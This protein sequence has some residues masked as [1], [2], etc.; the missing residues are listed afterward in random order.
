MIKLAQM[1][2]VVACGRLVRNAESGTAACRSPAASL[3]SSSQIA[4]QLCLAWAC[5]P[6]YPVCAGVC[7]H[8]IPPVALNMPGTG[9]K[10]VLY[11]FLRMHLYPMEPKTIYHDVA[12]MY[13]PWEQRQALLPRVTHF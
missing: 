10:F 9:E 4:V 5:A 2:S 7:R 3:V 1:L 11:H 12:C 13:A 8:G 6:V